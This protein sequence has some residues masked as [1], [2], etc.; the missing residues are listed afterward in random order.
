MPRA[1]IQMRRMS[2]S[3]MI[4]G[5]AGQDSHP[6]LASET[7]PPPL[8]LSLGKALRSGHTFSGKMSQSKTLQGC[9]DLPCVCIA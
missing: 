7:P 6:T 3:A 4:Q 1:L 8:M 5:M 9:C 2:L